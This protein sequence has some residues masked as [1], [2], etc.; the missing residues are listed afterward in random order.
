MFDSYFGRIT[1]MLGDLFLLSHYR[2]G[3]DGRL[4]DCFTSI[5]GKPKSSTT[6]PE[7]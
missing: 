3:K 6:M 7:R 2:I 1:N 4:A 5:L